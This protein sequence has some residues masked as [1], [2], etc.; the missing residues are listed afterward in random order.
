MRKEILRMEQV[1][2]K[3]N[4]AEALK[5]LCLTIYGGEIL[6]LPGLAVQENQ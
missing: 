4:G 3:I 5:E 1:V 2:K 6:A